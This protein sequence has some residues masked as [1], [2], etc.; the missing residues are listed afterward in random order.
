MSL[1]SSD[2]FWRIKSRCRYW[3]SR[4]YRSTTEH[5]IHTVA[6]L[7]LMNREKIDEIQSGL[8]Q[9]AKNKEFAELKWCCAR[10]ALRTLCIVDLNS[11]NAFISYKLIQSNVLIAGADIRTA[12][13]YRTA[14]AAAYAATYAA[15]AAADA[16]DHAFTHALA[17]LDAA[18]FDNDIVARTGCS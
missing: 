6:V 2:I 3:L 5:I 15:D 8:H 12:A 13:A 18:S 10:I 17:S 7:D 16:A 9:L 11:V 1:N 14:D 4:L